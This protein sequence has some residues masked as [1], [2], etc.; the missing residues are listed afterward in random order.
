MGGVNKIQKAHCRK[1]QRRGM[2]PNSAPGMGWTMGP[3]QKCLGKEREVWGRG[4][5]N[6]VGWKK[7]DKIERNPGAETLVVEG[8]RGD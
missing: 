1:K 5:S 8:G 7:R 6:L 3:P 4:G 2:T